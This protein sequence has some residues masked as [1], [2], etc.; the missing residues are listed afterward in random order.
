MQGILFLYILVILCITIH[1]ISKQEFI[2]Y[3]ATPRYS[4]NKTSF[5]P[6]DPT[7]FPIIPRQTTDYYRSLATDSTTTTNSSCVICSSSD[8]DKCSSLA[9]EGFLGLFLFLQCCCYCSR[10]FFF[11]LLFLF[12]FLIYGYLFS[13]V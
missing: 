6:F 11:L 9:D 3:M 2:E 12:C 8:V 10:S 4:L 13:Y 5:N 1:A 7:L